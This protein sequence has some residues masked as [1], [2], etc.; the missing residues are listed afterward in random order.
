[1]LKEFSIVDLMCFRNTSYC[2]ILLRK[3]CQR[4]KGKNLDVQSLPQTLIF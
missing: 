4:A 3:I 2:L 1:V